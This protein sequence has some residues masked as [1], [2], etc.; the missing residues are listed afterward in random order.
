MSGQAAVA[1]TPPPIP[2]P[3]VPVAG[4][5]PFPEIAKAVGCALQG[6]DYEGQLRC[7]RTKSTEQLEAALNT[8]GTI[9]VS[10]FVDNS[11]VFSIPE[12]KSRGRAGKFARIVSI[13]ASIRDAC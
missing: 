4:A 12:Y 6:N 7:V 5:N 2:I 13:C 11:T 9:G 3:G 10:P 1:L 8:T